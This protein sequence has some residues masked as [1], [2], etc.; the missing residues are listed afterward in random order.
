MSVT[1]QMTEGRYNRNSQYLY[2]TCFNM[3]P[4]TSTPSI[5]TSYTYVP[6]YCDL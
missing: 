3:T 2:Q 1:T 5:C 6:W 4:F